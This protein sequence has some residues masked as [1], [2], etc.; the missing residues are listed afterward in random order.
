METDG[1]EAAMNLRGRTSF[2]EIPCCE[3][4]A[5]FAENVAARQ[6]GP[7]PQR[8]GPDGLGLRGSHNTCRRYYRFLTYDAPK[9]H[10]YC[11]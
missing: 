5:N 11:T 1:D 4:G 6:S 10:L 3:L 7:Y 8:T 9:L 2:F